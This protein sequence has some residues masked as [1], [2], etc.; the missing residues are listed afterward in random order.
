MTGPT[1]VGNTLIIS[2]QHPGEDCPINDGTNLSRSIEMLDL[3][4]TTFNQTRNVPRGSSW[5][6][7]IPTADGGND[8]PTGV[9]RP[10][11]IGIR[12]KDSKRRFI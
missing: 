5:P 3:N 12:R 10:S 11:V 8:Q 1:F 7:N 4:G 9:P 2:V 6:S